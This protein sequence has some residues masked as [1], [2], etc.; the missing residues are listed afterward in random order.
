MYSDPTGQLISM[1]LMGALIGFVINFAVSAS[2][3]FLTEGEVNWGTAAIDGAFGAVSG[4]LAVTGI[5]AAATFFTNTALSAIN[6]TITTGLE[7]N[8]QFTKTDLLF[9]G[10]NALTSGIISGITRGNA[11]KNLLPVK[12]I[13]T[14]AQARINAA[15]ASNCGV[16]QVSSAMSKYANK[17]ILR[18]FA[19]DLAEN[20]I[21]TFYQN[22]MFA[23]WRTGLEGLLGGSL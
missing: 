12:S 17:H 7:N 21:L 18:Y 16:K 22:M 5:G 1:L 3:Q 14:Q 8:W 15:I 13:A 11:L 23:S 19:D 2:T 4:A 6:S 9:I 10:A 20:G